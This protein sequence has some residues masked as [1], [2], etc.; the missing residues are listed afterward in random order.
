MD[1]SLV[2][3][4]INL[5]KLYLKRTDYKAIKYAEGELTESEYAETKAMRKSWRNEIN[6]LEK[7]L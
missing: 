6:E 7:K 2:R 1:K 3:N 4:K 5:L